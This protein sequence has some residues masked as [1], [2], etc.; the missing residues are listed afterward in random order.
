[1]VSSALQRSHFS[2]ITSA[3]TDLRPLRRVLPCRAAGI[4]MVVLRAKSNLAI[5]SENGVL[6]S[7]INMTAIQI[8]ES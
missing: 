4:A 7:D 5:H 1:M 6:K 8:I 3:P 2:P